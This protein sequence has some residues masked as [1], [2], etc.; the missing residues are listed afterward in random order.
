MM[1][2]PPQ[3]AET[4]GVHGQLYEHVVG[5]HDQLQT[6]RMR[7]WYHVSDSQYAKRCF[8]DSCCIAALQRHAHVLIACTCMAAILSMQ[9]TIMASANIGDS[10]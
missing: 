6:Q 1:S 8:S 2:L 7:S 9:A 5:L 10:P 3:R 4:V